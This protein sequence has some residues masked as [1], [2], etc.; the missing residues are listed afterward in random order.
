MARPKR[1]QHIFITYLFISELFLSHSGTCTDALWRR[2]IEDSYEYS[3]YSS[4]CNRSEPPLELPEFSLP[5][6]LPCS[7]ETE[8]CGDKLTCCPDISQK[9]TGRSNSSCLYPVIHSERLNR[10]NRPDNHVMF[11]LRMV[12]D[13]ALEYIGSDLHEKCLLYRNTSNMD[14][15]TPVMSNTTGVIYVNRFCAECSQIRYFEAF[16]PIFVCWYELFSP[17]NWDQLRVE[18]TLENQY[19]L[20]QAGL[21]VYIFRVPDEEKIKANACSNP[22]YTSC[23]QTGDMDVMDPFLTEACEAYE[24]PYKRQYRNIHCFLCNIK[25]GQQVYNPHAYCP[26]TKLDQYIF[27]ISFYAI[28][29]VEQFHISDRV[30]S[31][32]K[33]CEDTAASMHDRYLVSTEFKSNRYSPN[34]FKYRN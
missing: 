15:L 24:L 22:I 19:R 29:D 27:E 30:I 6:V 11:S 17:V 13:C 16:K 14:N 28:I 32:N 1:N 25:A 20:T 8:I 7:C 21:C 9:P 23:N 18:W 5:C 10:F 26:Q 31:E 34:V 4:F 33:Q 2:I 12:H 3:P